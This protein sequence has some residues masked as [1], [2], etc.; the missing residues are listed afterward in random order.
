MPQKKI[1]EVL[2]ELMKVVWKQR[3]EE[4]TEPYRVLASLPLSI[5]ITT[6]LS[7]L[8]EQAL[9]DESKDP[10]VEFS[11]WNPGTKHFPSIYDDEPQYRPDEDRP[12]VYHLFG[13]LEEPRSLVLTEDDY[14][15]YLIGISRKKDPL[16]RVV[17]SALVD[18][19][20]L[21]LGFQV[22]D[23]NF[24]VLFRNIM[25]IEGRNMRSEHTHV[26]AQI[27]PEEGRILMPERARRYIEEYF[28]GA[29][30]SIYWG[31]V[32]DFARELHKQLE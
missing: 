16:P 1:I 28:Q 2:Q 24:R 6:D 30:I 8:L 12:L 27:S 4:Q 10:Q 11:R 25:N 23:W 9:A 29:D 22:D 13:Y 15:D 31:S 7:N 3:S 17:R 20:L 19:A 18:T 14:F 21:F 26:A 5:Y 32:E